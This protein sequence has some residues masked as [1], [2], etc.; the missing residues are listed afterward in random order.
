MKSGR[1]IN[2]IGIV[3]VVLYLILYVTD[4]SLLEAPLIFIFFI[5]LVLG[6]IGYI[7]GDKK[8]GV[9]LMAITVLLF[10]GVVS[11]SPVRIEILT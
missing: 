3:L 7:E 10:V 9:F 6:L 2:L 1:I 4:L 5:P 11:L 8:L